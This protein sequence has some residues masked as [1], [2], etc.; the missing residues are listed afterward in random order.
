MDGFFVKDFM[1]FWC[2]VVVIHNVDF[3]GLNLLFFM[4]LRVDLL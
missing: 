1:L 2:V 4:D 3:R